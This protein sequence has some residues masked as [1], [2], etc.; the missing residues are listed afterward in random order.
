MQ[1]RLRLSPISL[2]KHSKSS[3]VILLMSVFFV[4]VQACMAATK[5]DAEMRTVSKIF[6]QRVNRSDHDSQNFIGCAHESGFIDYYVYQ[7]APL[8]SATSL[9]IAITQSGCAQATYFQANT[10][11]VTGLSFRHLKKEHVNELNDLVAQILADSRDETTRLMPIDGDVRTLYGSSNSHDQQH[12]YNGVTNTFQSHEEYFDTLSVDFEFTTPVVAYIQCTPLSADRSAAIRAKN[13]IPFFDEEALISK[14]DQNA[15][16]AC[17][18]YSRVFV[19]LDTHDLTN[20]FSAFPE[21]AWPLIRGAGFF[22]CVLSA[23]GRAVDRVF[24]R[25]HSTGE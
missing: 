11:I 4:A 15:L 25:H 12:L 10:L 20:L 18:S 9:Q 24:F 6:E 14:L 19:P 22:S 1:R 17:M 16:A 13:G 3:Q 2:F 21:R 23:G 5:D 8:M 7:H